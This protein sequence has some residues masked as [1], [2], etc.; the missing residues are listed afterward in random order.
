M[1]LRNVICRG[2]S[3]RGGKRKVPTKMYRYFNYA[4]AMSFKDTLCYMLTKQMKY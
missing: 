1:D 3:G 4:E 2:W